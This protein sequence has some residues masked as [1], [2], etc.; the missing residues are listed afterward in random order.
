VKNIHEQ[1][2]VDDDEI[3]SQVEN[4]D[5]HVDVVMLHIIDDDDEVDVDVVVV[6]I[7]HENDTNEYLLYHMIIHVDIIL[8][9][10]IVY[11]AAIEKKYIYL[12]TME[13]YLLIK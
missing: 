7:F 12:R 8:H 9:D 2:I 3:E 10:E 1:K 6:V 13:L 11:T 5:V 4:D